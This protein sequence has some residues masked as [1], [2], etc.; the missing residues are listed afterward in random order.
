MRI[1]L[2]ISFGLFSLISNSG[3]SI[4]K[5]ATSHASEELI[6]GYEITISI[7]GSE[8][9]LDKVMDV[10]FKCRLSITYVQHILYAGERQQIKVTIR[11]GD[12]K[13]L[14]EAETHLRSVSNV[15]NISIRKI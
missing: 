5:P 12:N 9:A 1:L 11:N 6:P 7:V 10:F 13:L 2:S 8:N 4:S 15:E 14:N 3:C